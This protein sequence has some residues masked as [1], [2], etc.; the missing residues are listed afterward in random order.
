[1]RRP[2]RRETLEISSV[3]IIWI[4]RV[5]AVD[6][7]SNWF[8]AQE[9]CVQVGILILSLLMAFLLAVAAGYIG[10]RPPAALMAKAKAPDLGFAA[11]LYDW[12]AQRPALPSTQC[13]PVDP[14]GPCGERL[15]ASAEKWQADF[16]Q[17]VAAIQSRQYYA[18]WTRAGE[19]FPTYNRE[20]QVFTFTLAVEGDIRADAKTCVPFL[21]IAQMP[22]GITAGP[23][24]DPG[25]QAAS[26]LD[27]LKRLREVRAKS[28][29]KPHPCLRAPQWTAWVR[30]EPETARIWADRAKEKGWK[31]EMY[32]RLDRAESLLLSN[33]DEDARLTD[34]DFLKEQRIWLWVDAVRLVIGDLVVHEWR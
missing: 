8:A 15:A 12:M 34:A 4:T 25:S 11:A 3:I 7:Y 1:M 16:S 13:G 10:I 31:L 32:F 2:V 27:I 6:K 26:R 30:V 28:K 22:S 29:P 24:P 23:W 17:Y 14:P 19:E 9:D 21:V 33:W 18:E 20:T 5:P